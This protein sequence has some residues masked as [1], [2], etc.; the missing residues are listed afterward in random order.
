MEYM[1]KFHYKHSN[2]VEKE[3]KKEWNLQILKN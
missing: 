3:F 1:H 2:D